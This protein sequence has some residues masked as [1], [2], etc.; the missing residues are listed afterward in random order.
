M[1]L[2]IIDIMAF[3]V[4]ESSVSRFLFLKLLDSEIKHLEVVVIE[5]MTIFE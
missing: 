2:D 4:L 3:G 1:D 5:I